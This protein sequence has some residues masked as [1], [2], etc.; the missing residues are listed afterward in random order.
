MSG[1]AYWIAKTGGGWAVE[2]ESQILAVHATHGAAVAHL[3]RLAGRDDG[4]ASPA[5]TEPPLPETPPS[6][7]FFRRFS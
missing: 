2:G 6:D 4:A 7:P 1:S 5:Q 3:D